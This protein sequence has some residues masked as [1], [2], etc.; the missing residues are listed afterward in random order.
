MTYSQIIVLGI[1]MIG[2]IAFASS[3]AMV[4]IKKNMDI[5]GVVVLAITTAV[6]GGM[7]RDLILGI[8]LL[9]TSRC[10]SETAPDL[11]TSGDDDCSGSKETDSVDDLGAKTGNVRGSSKIHINILPGEHNQCSAQ[12]D[13]RMGLNSCAPALNPP[14]KTNEAADEKSKQKADKYIGKS[15]LGNIL[16]EVDKVA[17]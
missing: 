10:V 2:T 13:K 4:G 5:F 3:G 7:I 16:S 11:V 12:A 17:H 14:V 15:P 9:Y 8:C 1:E 6:G